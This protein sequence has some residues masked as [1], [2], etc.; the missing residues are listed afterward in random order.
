MASESADTQL[1][2]WWLTSFLLGPLSPEQT[3]RQRFRQQG[4]QR[5]ELD[6]TDDVV[7]EGLRQQAAGIRLADAPRAKIK[8]RLRVDLPDRRPVRALDIVGVDLELRL[9]VDHRF[10]GQQKVLVALFRVGLLSVLAHDDLS[11]EDAFRPSVQDPLVNFP[12]VA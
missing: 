1:P 10:F 9:G 6:S 5:F 7:R 11:V 4:A 3:S 12:A 8:E 2:V